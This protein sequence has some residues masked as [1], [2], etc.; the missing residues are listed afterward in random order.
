MDFFEVLS[1]L[2]VASP[3]EKGKVPNQSAAILMMVWPCLRLW[4][5][6]SSTGIGWLIQRTVLGRSYVGSI[7]VKR[8]LGEKPNSSFF[9]FSSSIEFMCYLCA[10]TNTFLCP[11]EKTCPNNMRRCAV[12]AIRKYLYSGHRVSKPTCT[13]LGDRLS[14]FSLQPDPPLFWQLLEVRACSQVLCSAH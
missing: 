1:C 9:F 4:Q 5:D 6:L 12:I 14:L 10:S 7:M 8:L 3:L 13:S 11:R 2:H